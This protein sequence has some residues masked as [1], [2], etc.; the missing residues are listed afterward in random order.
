MARP[1]RI[2][3][4]F[5]MAILLGVLAHNIFRHEKLKP[6]PFIN[7]AVASYH[8]ARKEASITITKKDT[9]ARE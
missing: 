1:S 5:V 4:V 9:K 6:A 3:A 7:A 2:V 8:Q